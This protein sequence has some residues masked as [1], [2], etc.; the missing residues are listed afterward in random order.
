MIGIKMSEIARKCSI[1]YPNAKEQWLSWL[2]NV[3]LRFYLIGFILCV[4]AVTS[5]YVNVAQIVATV[6]GFLINIFLYKVVT[7]LHTCL[8]E[9][10][11]ISS[12]VSNFLAGKHFQR[13]KKAT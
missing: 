9:A 6:K 5:R 12:K 13:P 1:L 7:T 4:F 10:H 8:N 2:N 3:S 11:M